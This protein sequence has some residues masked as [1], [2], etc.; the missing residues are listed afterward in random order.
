M[1]AREDLIVV[2]VVAILLVDK[3]LRCVQRSLRR[4]KFSVAAHMVTSNSHPA[5][6]LV[7]IIHCM[8]V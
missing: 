3:C 6:N 5:T 2:H 8:A 1:A 7:E 4:L